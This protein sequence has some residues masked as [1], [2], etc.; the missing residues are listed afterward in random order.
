[1]LG[2]GGLGEALSFSLEGARSEYIREKPPEKKSIRRDV[3]KR[4]FERLIEY[5]VSGSYPE[6]Y[7]K[8]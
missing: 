8:L 4:S 1:M 3:E 5:G 7:L 2:A 6:L